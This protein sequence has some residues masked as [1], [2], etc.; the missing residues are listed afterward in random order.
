MRIRYGFVAIAALA[1]LCCAGCPSTNSKLRALNVGGVNRV[2]W[3]YVPS[4]Y[5]DAAVPLVVVLH[6]E[7]GTAAQVEALSNFD[8]IAE[9]EGFIVAYP[10][11]V[12][13]QWND[14]R[15]QTGGAA[16]TA[17]DV[18]FLT[19]ML[20]SIEAEFK[21]DW[22]RVYVA[23]ESNGALMCFRLACEAPQRFAAIASIAGALP[24]PVDANCTPTIPMP[25]VMFN[26]TADQVVPYDGGPF[27]GRTK[28][29]TVLSAPDTAAFWATLDQCYPQPETVELADADSEDDTLVFRETYSG[30]VYGSEVVLY[31]IEGGGHSWPGGNTLQEEWVYGPVSRDIYASQLT[32]DFFKSHAR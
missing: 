28:W 6:A 20:D 21:I 27:N 25:V 5:A 19:S 30:G 3:V 26:G 32:W 9:R 31:R 1:A 11:G 18:G 16:S 24:Q 7:M 4:G 17:D 15:V 13:R 12:N 29:G 14:G 23:G 2:F 8:A 22:H 10:E